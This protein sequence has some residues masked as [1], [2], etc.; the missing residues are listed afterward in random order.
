[1]LHTA[2]GT[3][4]LRRFIIGK[5]DY[6]DAGAYPPHSRLKYILFGHYTFIQCINLQLLIVKS[7]NKSDKRNGVVIPIG[8]YLNIFSVRHLFHIVNYF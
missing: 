5:W 2:L 1:L 8:V 6:V 3:T 7:Y 4:M